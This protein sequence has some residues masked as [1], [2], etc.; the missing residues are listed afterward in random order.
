M[1]E[2]YE[3]R[4]LKIPVFDQ[5]TGEEIREDEK[6]HVCNKIIGSE[7]YP[8]YDKDTADELCETLNCLTNDYSLN[9]TLPAHKTG[10]VIGDNCFELAERI[11][12]KQEK[13]NELQNAM[14]HELVCELAYLEKSNHIKL[15]SDEVKEALNLSKNPTEK[16]IQAYCEETYKK[17]YTNL[18]IAKTNVTFINKQIDLINDYISLEKYILRKELR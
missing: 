5:E 11:H 16:Q 13:L 1:I 7:N 18:K 12:E 4:L 6:Y 10:M 15:H 14:E 3:V 17:E 2:N 8:C 9:K